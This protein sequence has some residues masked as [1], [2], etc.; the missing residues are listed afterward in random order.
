MP[1]KILNKEQI[2][3]FL[4]ENKKFLE[5]EFGVTKIA[6]FGSYARDEQKKTS[7]IDLLITMK[8]VDFRK[9]LRLKDFLENHFKTKVDVGYFDSV[10]V[11]IMRYIQQDLMYV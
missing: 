5:E 6:L 1:T 7:D 4:R 9:R 2:I 11:F 10:R 8:E 3:E